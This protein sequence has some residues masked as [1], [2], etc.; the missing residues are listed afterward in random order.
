MSVVIVLLL[1]RRPLVRKA[2]GS[3]SR[4]RWDNRLPVAIFLSRASLSKPDARNNRFFDCRCLFGNRGVNLITLLV[5]T[6]LQHSSSSSQ[7]GNRGS[8]SGD[9]PSSLSGGAV[10]RVWTRMGI[11]AAMAIHRDAHSHWD[12]NFAHAF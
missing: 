2:K 4:T 7:S 5:R 6:F 9:P 11:G 10:R 12:S 1:I 3:F 8:L